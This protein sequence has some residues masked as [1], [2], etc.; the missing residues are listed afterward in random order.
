M[1]APLLP[2][3]SLSILVTSELRT[4]LSFRNFVAHHVEYLPPVPRFLGQPFY[5][6]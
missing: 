2:V 1:M 4:S 5:A 3:A 6:T